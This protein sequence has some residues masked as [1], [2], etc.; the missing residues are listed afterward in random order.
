MP[1]SHSFDNHSSWAWVAKTNWISITSNIFGFESRKTPT[2]FS[3]VLLCMA[4]LTSGENKNSH[5]QKLKWAEILWNRLRISSCLLKYIMILVSLLVSSV[6]PYSRVYTHLTH[7]NVRYKP[8]STTYKK[9][10]AEKWTN[11]RIEKA[12]KTERNHLM[13]FEKVPP[14]QMCAYE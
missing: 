1:S 6:Y 10:V 12:T 14:F 9:C 7:C 13:H 2:H 11:T 8:S 4:C 3:V 5:R